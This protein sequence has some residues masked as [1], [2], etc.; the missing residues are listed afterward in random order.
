MN[1]RNILV[2]IVCFATLLSC[3]KGRKKSDAYGNFEAVDVTVS[4]EGTG[5]IIRFELEE[6]NLL[7]AGDIVG[8]I[9]T[10]QLF[11]KKLQLQATL[12]AIHTKLPDIGTQIDVLNEQ[13]KTAQ[14]EKL[15]VENLV[16]SGAATTKQ[17]DD[18][19]AQ[20]Q[21]FESQRNALQSTLTIQTKSILAEIEP[22]KAQISQLDDLITKSKIENPLD[23]TVLSKFAQK[24][25][26]ATPGKPLYKIAN[27]ENIIL[28]AYFSGEQISQVAIGQRVKVL[29]DAPD[30]EYFEYIGTVTW[31]ASKAEFS[32]KI[33]QTKDE[34][35]NLV[36]A[37][38]I[39][40]KNDGKIKI[41]MPG[42]LQ[43]NTK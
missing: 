19:T 29:I 10:V 22:I 30:N 27:I 2:A 16:K 26:L 36:Y 20:I 32:P 23:G 40:V 1:T 18:V 25:E 37:A 39:T 15:R 11:L 14:T 9:D 41:G 34:R 7:K 24:G 28:R 13:L 42:E 33:I 3:S 17:L 38:K 35:V 6:G 8:C 21:I 43:F 5:K 31:I 4:A 12:K